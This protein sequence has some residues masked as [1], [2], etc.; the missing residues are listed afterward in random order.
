VLDPEQNVSF[1]D[2][3]IEMGYDLSKVMFIATANSLNTV[4]PALIDR[5]EVIDITGY[6][7]EEKMEI[8]KRHLVLKQLNEHGVKKEQ[9]TFNKKT[10]Q[11]LIEDYTREAGVRR[12]EKNIAKIIRSTAKHIVNKE[13]YNTDINKDDLLKIMGPPQYQR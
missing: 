11:I 13:D 5:M 12:L 10:I 3:F 8:A 7:I 4:P 9:L 1:Y 2:N 6:I